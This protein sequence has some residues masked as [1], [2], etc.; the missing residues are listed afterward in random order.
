MKPVITC[1]EF[2]RGWVP[3]KV[4][5]DPTAGMIKVEKLVNRCLNLNAALQEGR[6]LAA[7]WG[8]TFNEPIV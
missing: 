4:W 6:R 1:N 7:R 3:V 8:M 5:W 2:A